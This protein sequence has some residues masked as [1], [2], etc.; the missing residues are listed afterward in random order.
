[1]SYKILGAFLAVAVLVVLVLSTDKKPLSIIETAARTT[2]KLAKKALSEANAKLAA[3]ESAVSA[4]RVLLE[5]SEAANLAN[6]RS[7]STCNQNTSVLAD[8]VAAAEL[9]VKTGIDALA[10]AKASAA[11]RVTANATAKALLLEQAQSTNTKLAL[12]RQQIADYTAALNVDDQVAYDKLAA[13]TTALAIEN[14]K[15][16][17]ME[18]QAIV[19]S[20]ALTA[21]EQKH[22]ALTVTLTDA[23]NT[24]AINAALAASKLAAA[25]KTNDDHIIALAV[26]ANAVAL[27]EAA[28]VAAVTVAET[29]K[30]NADLALAAQTNAA[31]AAAASAVVALSLADER[32]NSALA[33][34]LAAELALELARNG[35]AANATALA[36]AEQQASTA[37]ALAAQ[38]AV[39]ATAAEAKTAAAVL[40]AASRGELLESAAAAAIVADSL[41]TEW[42]QRAVQAESKLAALTPLAEERRILAESAK[43]SADAANALAESRRIE[44]VALNISYNK[45]KADLEIAMGQ[46]AN[47]AETR[48]LLE[49]CKQDNALAVSQTADANRLAQ[50]RF[51]AYDEQYKRAVIAEELAAQRLSQIATANA[52][53]SRLS[54]EYLGCYSDCKLGQAQA[55]RALPKFLGQKTWQ[56]CSDESRALGSK[57]FA[58]QYR[59][60]GSANPTALTA[61]CYHS[62]ELTRAVGQGLNTTCLP[63]DEKMG[64]R[65]CSNALYIN[66]GM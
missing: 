51:I 48:Q 64:G 27:A 10:A 59:S 42:R 62:N 50:A 54:S 41:T 53:V 25:L 14:N 4:Q 45:A 58:L 23:A 56:Q 55:D 32:T 18:Q 1:M 22:A 3:S 2:E 19:N 43:A 12:A 63:W 21:L 17:S 61:Q 65:G 46:R 52:T 6:S 44:L 34:K 36:Q 57:Y 40:L 38:R 24:T 47:A 29:Q 9:K 66:V 30:I 16:T 60:S 28:T 49:Q 11:A 33:A 26:S 15:V 35:L 31:S 20:A 7:L 39:E 5:K 37:L 8:K 13:L